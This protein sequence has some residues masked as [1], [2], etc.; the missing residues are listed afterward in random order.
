MGEAMSKKKITMH[1]DLDDE[2]HKRVFY[3]LKNLPANYSEPDL[4]KSIILFIN[5]IVNSIGECE[6]RKIRCEEV[7]KSLLGQQARGRIE[8]Q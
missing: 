5:G 8:W 2:M 7:L 4:S 6:E 1:F 3:A